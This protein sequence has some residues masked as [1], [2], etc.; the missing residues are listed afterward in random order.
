MYSKYNKK[1]P[2]CKGLVERI[3]SIK[4]RQSSREEQLLRVINV[5]SEPFNKQRAIMYFT[6]LPDILFWT[7]NY[8]F[9]MSGDENGAKFKPETLAE[10]IAI[11]ESAGYLLS[12]RINLEETDNETKELNRLL[13]WMI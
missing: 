3:C 6:E 7:G 13:E 8:H 12:P 10:F 2:F 11:C 9:T 5:Y 1:M 4:G